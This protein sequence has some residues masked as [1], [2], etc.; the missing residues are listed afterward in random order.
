[1]P[2]PAIP[3]AVAVEVVATQPTDADRAAI[4]RLSTHD[5]M[6]LAPVAYVVKVRLKSMPP[7]TSRGWALYVD[8]L[9]IPKYWQY[10]EG[11]YFKVFDPQFF[12]DH[13]GDRLRFS[14]DGSDF[15]DTGLRL[16]RPAS[17]AKKGS[18]RAAAKLPLQADVLS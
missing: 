4:A 3:K 10:R 5:G 2:A 15:V 12:L 6:A 11:I 13:Q 16:S 9:R 14:R 1:M 17:R 18:R 7:I 8:D